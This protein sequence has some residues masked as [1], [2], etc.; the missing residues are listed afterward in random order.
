[1][2]WKF[3]KTVCFLTKL[4][5]THLITWV[6]LSQWLKRP[7][8]FNSSMVTADFYMW[9]R[10]RNKLAYLAITFLLP[11]VVRDWRCCHILA[12]TTGST[13]TVGSSRINNFGLCNRA[14]AK[15][16][17]RF[18]PPLKAETLLAPSG[19]SRRSWLVKWFNFWIYAMGS[20]SWNTAF[21]IK[22]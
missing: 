5:P 10:H 11:E 15:D 18:W 6:G 9:N 21:Q 7:I 20:R 12:L 14:T 4:F 1:M 16:N 8:L 13:P 19:R 3:V 22:M 2:F 17:L